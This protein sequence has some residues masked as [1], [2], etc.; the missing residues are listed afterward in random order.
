MFRTKKKLLR[1]RLM[2]L[3]IA[4][5]L[6][7]GAVEGGRFYV[8]VGT[9]SDQ[10]RARDFAAALQN[11]FSEASFTYDD[12]RR[13]YYVHVMNTD[14]QEEAHHFK[15]SLQAD[16]GFKDAWIFTDVKTDV[17]TDEST[18]GGQATSY[19][20]SVRLELLTGGSV[21]LSS[22]DNSYLSIS[23]QAEEKKDQTSSPQISF[24]I[25]AETRAGHSLPGE[26]SVLDKRGDKLLAFKTDEIISFGGKELAHTLILVC[27]VPGY[28]PEAKVVDLSNFTRV[29]DISTDKEGVWKVRFQL[30]KTNIDEINLLYHDMFHPDAAVFRAESE[31]Q[32][33]VLRTLL[34]ANPEW[35]IAINSHC[36]AGQKRDIFLTGRGGDPFDISE[37][38]ERSGTD[39]SLTKARAETLRDYLANHGIDGRRI[40]VMGWGSLNLVVKRS[41]PNAG[42]NDRT[43]VAYSR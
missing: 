27:R 29:P 5:T 23:R 4:L 31:R 16:A 41:D 32:L 17:K 39:K 8:V 35:R 1:F 10:G 42:L 14:Q 37:A 6:L 26:V 21:L 28:H 34:R 43:E 36:N 3:F 11:V 30:T 22:A 13:L 19:G 15:H 40:T 20:E 2:G 9:F 18:A 38:V 25:V 33:H 7:S 24:I 12:A